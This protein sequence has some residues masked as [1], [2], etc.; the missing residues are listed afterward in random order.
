MRTKTSLK[1]CGLKHDNHMHAPSSW[2]A[3]FDPSQVGLQHYHVGLLSL[4]FYRTVL[5]RS[6]PKSF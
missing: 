1:L 5:Q 4:Q 2:L 6:Q 3:Y